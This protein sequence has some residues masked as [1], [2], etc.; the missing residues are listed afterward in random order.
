MYQQA[1]QKCSYTPTPHATA[2]IRLRSALYITHPEGRFARTHNNCT[3]TV[4][5]YVRAHVRLRKLAS[6]KCG[7]KIIIKTP[8]PD[9][10]QANELAHVAWV[11]EATASDVTLF[12]ATACSKLIEHV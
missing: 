12:L 8:L 2:Q 5:T 1:V 6:G 10:K 11:V 3:C 9:S 4:R 7:F